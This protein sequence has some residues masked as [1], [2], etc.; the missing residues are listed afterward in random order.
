M[1]A[2]AQQASACTGAKSYQVHIIERSTNITHTHTNTFVHV[3]FS[4][5]QTV[6]D[7]SSS[8]LIQSFIVKVT[9]ALFSDLTWPQ[10]SPPPRRRSGC[11]TRRYPAES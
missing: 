9:H 8:S 1:G 3:S 2:A 5:T 4:L 6:P 11:C 10:P 7:S